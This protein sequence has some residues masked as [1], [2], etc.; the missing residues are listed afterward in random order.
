MAAKVYKR[1][2][3]SW[4]V[5]THHAG[6]KSEKRFGPSKREKAQAEKVA[7]KINAMIALGQ[8]EPDRGASAV[9]EEIPLDQFLWDWHALYL[10]TFRASYRE[11]SESII[12][13]HLAPYFG[14][15]DLRGLKESDLLHYI[16]HKSNPD[17]YPAP[18]HAPTEAAALRAPTIRPPKRASMTPRPGPQSPATVKNAITLLRSALQHA[19]RE[20]LIATNP[21]KGVGKHLSSI[22]R[23]AA[24][25]TERVQAWTAQEVGH[26]LSIA[27]AHGD[28]RSLLK[29]LFAS[30]MRRGEALGL[31][32][33]DLDFARGEICIER[34]WVRGQLGLPKSGKPRVVGMSPAL[35]ETLRTL[36]RTRAEQALKFGWQEIPVPVFCSRTGSRL[37]PHN[38]NRTWKRVRERAHLLHGVS[39]LR[40]HSTRHTFASQALEAGKSIRFVADQLGHADPGF[41]LRIYAHWIRTDLAEMDFADFGEAD[42][43]TPNVI[44]RHYA[45]PAIDAAEQP[46]GAISQLVDAAKKNGDPGAIRTRDPQ[47]RRLVLYPAELP[48]HRRPILAISHAKT[49]V[50]R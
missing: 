21:A 38:V 6:K 25:E 41:T 9:P 36:R 42:S 15:S 32:W 40:L 30:G 48:G 39:P 17:L 13:V 29:L 19:V 22:A 24:L 20:G 16:N 35:Q 12:R 28:F 33:E 1:K 27:S 3:G 44:K 46:E 10:N 47:L 43:A 14:A 34:S 11:T 37:D 31:N 4:W 45:S 7:E 8:Y 49:N 18:G 2:D 26:L 50:R 23:S 5:R